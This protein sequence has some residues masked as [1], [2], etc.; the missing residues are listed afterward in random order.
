MLPCSSLSF[1]PAAD[2]P[3]LCICTYRHRYHTHS[4]SKHGIGDNEPMG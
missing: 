4:P 3:N 2:I 1:A